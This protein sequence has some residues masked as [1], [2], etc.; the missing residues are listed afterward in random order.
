MTPGPASRRGNGLLS[1]AWGPLVDVDPQVADELLIRLAAAQVAAYV[2]GV[3]GVGPEQPHGLERLW[4]DPERAD[5]ARSVLVAL[6]ADLASPEPL[7]RPVDR[8]LDPGLDPGL[9]PLDPP[10][11]GPAG[12]APLDEDALFQQIV[13]GYAAT[14][15]E[16]EVDW[17]DR[18][19]SEFP[20]RRRK[21][22]PPRR[23]PVEAL[24]AWV[25]PDELEPEEDDHFV[26][27]APPPLRWF[28]PRTILATLA[29]VAGIL[30]IFAPAVLQLPDSNG[31][32]V[33]GMALLLSGAGALVWW[34][35]DSFSD[36]DDGAIV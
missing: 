31:S 3:D 7:I 28:H 14:A 20:P 30:A 26:P 10:T 11:L 27:P 1:S 36:P 24:P 6:H 23:E 32:R 12:P 9:V 29:I 25:E 16:P 22:D 13:L 4:V 33:L 35:R 17:P 8:S 21:T 2:E 18:P 5:A 19:T 15:S 34:M